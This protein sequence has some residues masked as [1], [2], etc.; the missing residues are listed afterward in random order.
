MIAPIVITGNNVVSDAYKN[1]YIYNFPGGSVDL[2]G[3]EVALN[4]LNV[5]YSWY[6]ITDE[7][8]NNTFTIQHPTDTTP[9]EVE[10]TVPDG[11]Y[12]VDDLNG[13]LQTQLIAN[14]HYLINAAGE[15]VYYLEMEENSSVYGIQLNCY[16]LPTS[17][18]AGYSNPAS[19]PFPATT[20]TAKF[21]IDNQ[22][23]GNLIGF[24]IAT[25]PSTD[26]TETYSVTSDKTPI[27][28]PISA[29]IVRCS[30]V[31]NRL[32][33]DPS[34]LDVFTPAIASSYGSMIMH[35][36]DT[37]IFN[38][39]SIG[40]TN[41]LTVELVDQDNNKIKLREPIT[42]M[43]LSIKLPKKEEYEMLP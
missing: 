35:K 25:Y 6:N 19:M 41:Q 15:Y 29:V 2:S 4:S 26:P 39:V 43:M 22:L 16:S 23:F 33:T 37:L 31:N 38:P 14:G 27:I 3:S 12:S 32:N 9:A 13:Y 40:I 24:T 8:G 17:L 5:Y 34:V 7:K 18:P 28:N 36:H 10:I 11:Y 21:I 1:K 20:L 42:T 30:L